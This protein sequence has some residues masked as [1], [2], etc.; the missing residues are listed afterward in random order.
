MTIKKHIVLITVVLLL[1]SGCDSTEDKQ[2]NNQQGGHTTTQA[3]YEK[4][5]SEYKNTIKSNPNNAE[6]HYLLAK[7]EES[8][9]NYKQAIGHYLKAIELDDKHVKAMAR[10]GRVYLATGALDKA[11]ELVDRAL[12][13]SPQDA[14]VLALRGALR[15]KKGD[16]ESG[17]NDARAAR[18]IEPGNSDAISLLVV[19]YINDKKVDKAT[20][21]LEESLNLEASK[22]LHIMRVNLNIRI[23]RDGRAIELMQ[24]VITQAPN[25]LVNRVSLANFYDQKSAYYEAERVLR[26]AVKKLPNNYD[27]KLNLINY[28]ARRKSLD[29]AQT[30]LLVYLK[31]SPDS[32]KLKFSLANLY[33]QAKA[34]DKA[35]T[36]YKDII[37]ADGVNKDGLVARNLLIRLY[38]ASKKNDNAENLI[39]E[40]LAKSPRDT[41]A[42]I[43][44]ASFAVARKDFVAAIADYGTVLQDNPYQPEV[45]RELGRVYLA[46]KQLELARTQ[47]DKASA[48]DPGNVGLLLELAQIDINNENSE[49]AL[50]LIEIAHRRQ[51]Q[52]RAVLES[53]YK[54]RLS[55]KDLP[56]ALVVANKMKQIEEMKAEGFYAAGLVYQQQAKHEKS[57]KQFTEAL[58]IQPESTKLQTSLTRSLL[59]QKKTSKAISQLKKQLKN[60][61][62]KAFIH[63]L[64]GEIYVAQKRNKQGRLAF[65]KAMKLKPDWFIPHRNL[66]NL[67]I[68]LGDKLAAIK[69]YKKAEKATNGNPTIMFGLAG[70]YENTGQTDAA[71]KQFEKI[72]NK[73]PK[74]H[75][76]LNNLAILLATYRSDKKSLDQAAKLV[77]P[78]HNSNNPNYLDTVGW[79]YFKRGELQQAMPYLKKAISKAPKVPVI[80]YHFAMVLLK[81]GDKQTAKQHL[82]KALKSKSSFFGKDD[83]KAALQSLGAS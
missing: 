58:K 74:S 79:V 13:I 67:Q 43:M 41:D 23:G 17:L 26:T 4:A 35:E 75:G 22:E 11:T 72:V 66:G 21:L 52:N 6:A 3:N 38:I 33:Q 25:N 42:L 40:I 19:D 60:T 37:V 50:K 63:N 73:S 45:L 29:A 9:S 8:V 57:Y 65:E 54:L 64:L 34:I 18:K 28:L 44:R 36:V 56:G 77:E 48:A 32:N 20:A 7:S 12:K 39:T 27:A 47:Y 83:A 2:A 82:L 71:I 24:Q 62:N 76:A 10:M 80:N 51:P 49:N 70:L 68:Q 59:L 78:L 55:K 46:N 5:R 1:L 15:I 30:Q 53:L 81:S 61:S 31:D 16:K 14:S 69:T